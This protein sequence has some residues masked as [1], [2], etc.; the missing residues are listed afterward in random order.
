MIFLIIPKLLVT[1]L[2]SFD[3][4]KQIRFIQMFLQIL[5]YENRTLKFLFNYTIRCKITQSYFLHYQTY[6]F[7][8]SR[9][10]FELL[11]LLMPKNQIYLKYSQTRF[12]RTAWD[13][14]FLFVITGVRYKRVDLCT[15]KTKLT[16]KTVRYNREFV[17]NRVRY[18][19]VSL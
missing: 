4:I 8:L 13:R 7:K 14:P 17:N 16:S 2:Q 12:Q 18:N 19:R 10:S 1:T 15:K 6:Y 3:L 11:V 9:Q 5:N